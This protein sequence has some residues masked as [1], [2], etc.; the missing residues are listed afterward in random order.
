MKL[1]IS[2]FWILRQRFKLHLNQVNTNDSI[3]PRQNGTIQSIFQGDSGT[4]QTRPNELVIQ[5][6]NKD[7]P[8]AEEKEAISLPERKSNE[9]KRYQVKTYTL[10]FG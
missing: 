8:K 2:F 9:E 10:N 4:V 3:G 6:V 1:L 7:S 5:D